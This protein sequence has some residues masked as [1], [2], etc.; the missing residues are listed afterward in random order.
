MS[1]LRKFKRLQALL[2]ERSSLDNPVERVSH[3]YQLENLTKKLVTS[4][5][6]DADQRAFDLF[7]QRELENRSINSHLSKTHGMLDAYT[8]SILHRAG[9]H[10]ARVLGVL[11]LPSVLDGCGFGPGVNIGVG[12]VH[13]SAF[14][15]MMAV[16]TVTPEL[17]PFADSILKSVPRWAEHV[18]GL[19]C[20]R[21]LVVRGGHYFTVAKSDEVDRGC[22][23]QPLING[24][25]QKG[26]GKYLR[27][28]F[29]RIAGVD[30]TDQSKN[31]QLARKGSI[32]GSLATI[33]LSSASDSVTYWLVRELLPQDWFH[34]LDI[35]R[36]HRIRGLDGVWR[37]LEL[38]SSMGNGFTFELESIIF[39]AICKA[40]L[41]LGDIPDTFLSVYGD[42]IIVPVD[43]VPYV[44]PALKNV[45]FTVNAQKSFWHGNFR[46]SCGGDYY[47]GTCITPLKLRSVPTNAGQWARLANIIRQ[48]ASNQ[49]D[50]LYCHPKF[51][52]A[53]EFCA[54]TAF[55][56]G[57][58][59]GPL[60]LDGVVHTSLDCGELPPRF[61]LRARSLSQY[62]WT[63]A[64]RV[65]SEESSSASTG[66]HILTIPY[67]L[68]R[69]GSDVCDNLGSA[70][71]YDLR[72]TTRWRWVRRDVVGPTW[73]VPFPNPA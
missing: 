63:M 31:R 15:K 50:G 14:N 71:R 40:A 23:K 19:P 73:G 52:A 66:E 38:F 5:R 58:D 64:C 7:L 24:F 44:I 39:W 48:V 29:Y 4:R 53:W 43:G 51:R 12:G 45:G 60:E 41:E 18:S 13:T 28:R 9:R 22:E 32:D 56:L 6:G 33:D 2:S 27:S 37:E 62:S 21:K 30:L 10:I 49:G 16:P 17:M 42:D 34:L 35:A 59:F 47:S 70:S 54:K 26:I 20:Q 3:A 69:M 72:R 11:N 61:H 25:L 68:G 55:D 65:H 1:H 46:E 57:A 36:T 8:D 67:A